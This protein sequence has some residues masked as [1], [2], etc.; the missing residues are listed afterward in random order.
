MTSVL[1]VITKSTSYLEKH[2]IQEARQSIEQLL[3]QLLECSK[4]ELYLQFDLPLSE[5]QLAILRS[6]VQKRSQA[7]PLQHLL[8]EVVFFNHRF[9]C[10]KR[11]LIPRPETEELLAISL[12]LTLPQSAELL[13][14]GCGSG[15][16][17]LSLAKALENQV[18]QV[19]LA[20]ISEECLDIAQ[21]NSV[22][23]TAQNV[24][25]VK[26]D[27]F[28]NIEGKFDLIIANLPY[29][30]QKNQATLSK[31][32]LCDP[33]LALFGG[34]DGFEVLKKFIKQVSFHLK[35]QANV[36]LEVGHDQGESTR[37][38]L[39]GAGFQQVELLSD[40]NGIARFL[41]ASQSATP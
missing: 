8:G 40:L 28:S 30:P 7:I 12:Q 39:L 19:I 32:V 24:A 29:I 33:K 11:A 3:C 41:K 25:F 26:S 10:D 9:K 4:M 23:L 16:L 34:S 18:K 17:G 13:D 35:P 5:E 21:E 14:M 31:E 22:K 37:Q 15:V 20:D 38:L 1:D 36:L 6:Q 27:L 2:Q